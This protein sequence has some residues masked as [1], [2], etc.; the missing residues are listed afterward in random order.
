MHVLWLS[1]TH[2]ADE[3]LF[4][5]KLYKAPARK[6]VLNYSELKHERNSH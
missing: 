4:K 3:R 1:Y 5:E 6:Y 2:Q